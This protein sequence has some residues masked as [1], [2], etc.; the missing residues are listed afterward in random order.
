MD[1]CIFKYT[2]HPVFT[3]A[4]DY[5]VKYSRFFVYP[6]LN[7]LM[8]GNTIHPLVANYVI[9]LKFKVSR[10]FSGVCLKGHMSAIG[11]YNR[12]LISFDKN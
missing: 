1:K 7:R 11:M 2:E 9:M 6:S 3:R 10:Y 5:T 4:R 12:N 8:I